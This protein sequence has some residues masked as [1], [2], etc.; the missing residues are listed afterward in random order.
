MASHLLLYSLTIGFLAGY[1]QS[2]RLTNRHACIHVNGL[3]YASSKACPFGYLHDVNFLHAGGLLRSQRSL[4]ALH[5]HPTVL[6][7]C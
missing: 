6:L 4:P 3:Y 1:M 7:W 5:R 2:Q